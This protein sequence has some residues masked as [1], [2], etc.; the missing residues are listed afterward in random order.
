MT[1]E[2]F[3]NK[4]RNSRVEKGETPSQ[5]VDRL[6]NYFERWV[7]FGEV[8]KSFGNLSDLVLREQFLLNCSK[9]LAV[10]LK[11]CVPKTVKEMACL[12]EQFVEAHGDQLKLASGK[13][14]HIVG[15]CEQDFSGGSKTNLPVFKGVVGGVTVDT[16]HDS[17]C[18]GV[19]VKSNLVKAEEFTEKVY[20]CVLIDGTVK[21]VPIA[22]V[23]IDTPFFVGETDAMVMESP[24]YPLV[25]GNILGARDVNDPDPEWH[26]VR[27]ETK[28]VKEKTETVAV[29]TRSQAEKLNKPTSPL[30]LPS[31]IDL[32]LTSEEFKQ[33][34]IRD[35]SL[36][37][38]WDLAKQNKTMKLKSGN[39]TS[40]FVEKGF[41]YRRIQS[42]GKQKVVKQLLVP[43]KL[44]TKV[45]K[46]AHETL[47]G[48][49]L[50]IQKTLDRVMSS[51]YWPCLQSE[52]N[53]FC[54]S[55]DLCQKTTPKDRVPHVPLNKMPL[56]DTPF[57]RV[58]IDL[59][60]PFSPIT[61][62][63]NRYIL[64]M[65]DYATR[66]PEAIALQSIDTECVAEGLIE[67][68]SR[69]GVPCEILSDRGSQFMSQ[70]MQEVNRLLSVKHL[71][72]TPYHPQ[73][74]GL[75]EKFHFV[76][77]S[78]LRKLCAERPKDWDRYLPAVLF[79]YREVPQAS[80]GFSLFE[81]LYGRTVRGPMN[82]LK[83]LWTAEIDSDE[84]KSTYQYIVD[85]RER[86]EK[87]CKLA[88]ENLECA[89]EKGKLYFDK[90]SKRR[91]FEKNEKVLVLLPTE[92]NK[93]LVRWQ[94]PYNIVGVLG[95]DYRVE[96]KGKVKTYHANLLKKYIE[97][98]IDQSVSSTIEIAENSVL[99]VVSS[100]IIE[101]DSEKGTVDDDS[102][103]QFSCMEQTETYKDVVIN[104]DLDEQQKRDLSKLLVEFKDIFSD[105]PGYT[106][107]VKHEIDLTS[108]V[109]VRSKPYPIPHHIQGTVDSEI[110]SMLKM[111]VIKPFNSPYASP[112]VLVKKPDGKIRFC[113]DYRK[114]NR[115]TSF[116]TEP[117]V[118]ADQIFCK[119]KDSKWVSK[120]DMSKGYWQIAVDE[121][122]QDKTC[123]VTPK[124]SYCYLRMP[125]GLVNSAATFTRMM[126]LLLKGLDKSVHYIDDVLT[127][128]LGWNE[129]L[130][131]LRKLFE[132][133]R[134]AGLT[135][136][137]SKCKLGFTSVDYLGHIVGE[138]EISPN[139]EK[140][141]NI[142]QAPIPQTKKQVRS[143]LGLV[144]FYSKFIPNYS[145]VAAPLTDLTK[146]GCLNKIV[147][148]DAQERSFVILKKVLSSNPVLRL[149][150]LSREFIL[151]TDASEVGLGA[152]LLQDFDGQKFP[153]AYASKKL[154]KSELNYSVVEKECFALV[155]AI[156]KFHV[157]LYGKDFILETDHQPLVYLRQS[158]MENGRLVRWALALQPHQCK[159]RAIKGSQNVC[160]D[161]LSRL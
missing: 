128:S 47:L 83:D 17:G 126:R 121:S 127:H 32:G 92:T 86:L 115:L 59:V 6:T 1:E 68:F 95:D 123:F 52:V 34:Q 102:L 80:T 90:K 48:G 71:V 82:I 112:I 63:R 51:F 130:C 111:H 160:A 23:H 38:V 70:V 64:T 148:G 42:K 33:L 131:E 98:R 49:H 55:C 107:L 159:I 144:G 118:Q 96:V 73:C 57:Q 146:R 113:T 150:D 129:H 133:V 108:T 76:L 155:W 152:C 158:K 29:M 81:L 72:T 14:L 124:G 9:P 114:L 11:E 28:Q 56:I 45:L 117:M 157:Y 138:G 24:I 61:E 16:L 54:R 137:P 53:L 79:A 3:R 37:K 65:V 135:I 89:Q 35:N 50:G 19:V 147:W 122:S 85:L 125:F 69:V 143:F 27:E 18:T 151:Q 43:Q 120:C 84:T 60:G 110:E 94:G 141:F 21:K 88:Q 13:S 109:P 105:L 39:E 101:P 10:F 119:L 139:P 132:R 78:M 44:R 30:K 149:P 106:K 97:R 40:Y 2:G 7:E 140:L 26:C 142:Q 93:L 103:I 116:S 104:T 58:A 62:H 154:T 25:V 74:N 20:L 12:A 87:T 5:F 100:A 91:K 77:K 8:S 41:L 145:T 136:K 134:S 66:Y 46:L 4:F 22:K 36:N 15:V 67:I 153:V 31:E 75:V 99:Q 161:Y 156:R